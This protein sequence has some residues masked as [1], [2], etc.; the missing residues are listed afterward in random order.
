MK[1]DICHRAIMTIFVKPGMDCKQ[2]DGFLGD[3]N[4]M[5]SS[6]Q[7]FSVLHLRKLECLCFISTGKSQ[8]GRARRTCLCFAWIGFGKA[9]EAVEKPVEEKGNEKRKPNAH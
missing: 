7:H 4:S 1:R 8:D 9:E 5:F 2:I 6:G 3:P